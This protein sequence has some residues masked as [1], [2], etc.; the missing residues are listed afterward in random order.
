M[1][2]CR[3]NGVVTMELAEYNTLKDKA[4]KNK[5]FLVRADNFRDE[6]YCMK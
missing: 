1:A 3:S 5:K 2:L 6:Y 4:D